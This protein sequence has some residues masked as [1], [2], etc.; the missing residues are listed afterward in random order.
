MGGGLARHELAAAISD[1]GGLGQISVMGGNAIRREVAAARRMTTKPLAVNILLP[2]ARDQDF[3]AAQDAD[4]VVTFWGAPKRRTRGVW[5]HQVG[6][7]EEARA[8]HA[9][10]ADG[11]IAQGVEAGGHVRGTTPALALLE[12]VRDALPNGYPVL[13]AGGIAEPADVRVALDAG[14]EAAVAGTRFLLAEESRAHPGYKARLIQA[15]DT[16]LTELFGLSWPGRHRVVANAA[17]RRWIRADDPRGAP[18]VRAINRMTTP[19][20][21]VMSE[22]TIKQAAATQRPWLPLLSPAAAT[23]DLPESLVEAGPLYAGE[24]VARVDAIRPAAEL[25]RELAAGAA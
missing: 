21:R 7:V 20:A 8:A 12:Q 1:A 15:R 6:S 16:I 22:R 9:A 2:F 13:L 14:A 23:D 19:L 17:T 25:V 3:E 18:L 10:G 24:T 4:A 5:L 11:V